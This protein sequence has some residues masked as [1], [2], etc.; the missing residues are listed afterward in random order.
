MDAGALSI[1]NKLRHRARSQIIEQKLF[2]SR[3]AYRV[4]ESAAKNASAV[5]GQ[6]AA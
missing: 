1:G 5:A 4:K 2:S 6:E 3:N